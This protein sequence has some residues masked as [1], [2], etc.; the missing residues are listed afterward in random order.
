MVQK[1]EMIPNDLSDVNPVRLTTETCTFTYLFCSAQNSFSLLSLWREIFCFKNFLGLGFPE[2][3]M[4]KRQEYP[5]IVIL[6]FLIFISSVIFFC[7]ELFY[8]HNMLKLLL[9]E[10]FDF[11]AAEINPEHTEDAILWDFWEN[12]AFLDINRREMY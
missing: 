4:R 8:P 10:V 2:N 12:E 1:K 3:I 6:I 7:F 9:L 11:S 5:Y